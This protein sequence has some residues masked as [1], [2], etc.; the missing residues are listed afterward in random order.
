MSHV[1]MS[2]PDPPTLRKPV[3]ILADLLRLRAT[4]GRQPVMDLYA[5]AERLFGTRMGPE[6]LEETPDLDGTP[7]HSEIRPEILSERKYY[8]ASPACEGR[9][10]P[11]EGLNHAVCVETPEQ[12]IIRELKAEVERLAFVLYEL[13][14]D[15]SRLDAAFARDLID[16]LPT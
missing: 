16:R 2:Y 14:C 8:C 4:E 3:Q 12:I 15:G 7:A 6:V 9:L 1:E 10:L 13:D 5:E 11:P